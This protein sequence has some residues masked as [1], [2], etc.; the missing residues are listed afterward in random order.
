MR[1]EYDGL[2]AAG[3]GNGVSRVD[4]SKM[5]EWISTA[6]AADISGYHPEYVRRLAKAGK[7]GA[8]KKGRDWWI[9]R[10]RLR[11]YLDAVEELGNKKFDPHK[12]SE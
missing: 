12:G 10:D 6:E 7:I 2:Q 5:P 9:D 4:W 3:R 1:T 11:D 8:V